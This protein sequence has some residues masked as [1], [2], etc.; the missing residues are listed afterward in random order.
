M[1]EEQAWCPVEVS[2]NPD[3]PIALP[4]RQSMRVVN[5][6]H[7]REHLQRDELAAQGVHECAC[8][9]QPLKMQGGMGSTVAS[10]AVR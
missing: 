10:V 3:A 7:L 6:I 5:G 9:M 1:L 4:V 2:P 8:V